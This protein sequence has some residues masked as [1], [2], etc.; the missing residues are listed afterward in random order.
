[1]HVDMQTTRGR[2]DSEGESVPF[3]DER[4]DGRATIEWIAR[5]PWF[6]GRLGMAGPSYGGY[7]QWAAAADAPHELKA[8]VT[9]ITTT[10]VF[11]LAFPVDASAAIPG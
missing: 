10:R 8:I 6:D 11:D 1:M 3:V 4:A 9:H 5:Q 2:F 7:V